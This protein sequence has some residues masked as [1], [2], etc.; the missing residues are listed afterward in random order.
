MYTEKKD[1]PRLWR[2]LTS[3]RA[4]P[5]YYEAYYQMGMAYISLGKRGDA[6]TSFRKSIELSGDKYCR[7]G[8]RLGTVLL[9]KGDFAEAEKRFAAARN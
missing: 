1:Q 7:S 4:A 2:I 5:E 3:G 6:E 8:S 9:E